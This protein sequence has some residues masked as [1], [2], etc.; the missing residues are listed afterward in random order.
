MIKKAIAVYLD[1]SDKMETE[2]SWLYKTWLLWGLETE[3]DL[4]VYYN[5]E[6]KHRVDKFV[7]IKPI[8]M[9]YVRISEKYKFLNSHYFCHDVTAAEH[10]K[11]YDYLMKTDCDV[12][13][14][15][16]LKG[17]TPSKFMIG[18]GGYYQIED[19]K[20][21]EYI[22]NLSKEFGL[23]HKGYPFIGAS[24]FGKTPLVVSVTANQA[25]L[26]EKLLLHTQNDKKF[27]EVGFQSGIV[28]MIAGELIVNHL[29]TH[30]HFIPYC[31]DSKCWDTTKIGS[32]VLHIHAWHTTQKWSKHEYLN[33]DY[34]NWKVDVK[35]AFKNAANYC[36]FI[37]QLPYHQ[38]HELREKYKKGEF[39]PDYDLN[40]ETKPNDEKFSV[41]L[42][43][44]W[45]SDKTLKLIDDL[46]ECPLVDEI[47]IV[48]NSPKD[49]PKINLKK[50]KFIKQETNIYVNPSWNLG[51]KLAKNNL[52]AI[53]NDDI[54]F[55]VNETFNYVFNNKN[56]LGSIG[57]HP[58][59]YTN[60]NEIGIEIGYHTNGGGWGCLIFCKKDN[61][62]QIPENLKIGYG[63]DWIAITN[64]PT[65]SLKHKT[66][67]ITD[68]STTS[69]R[70]EF[71]SVVSSDIRTWKR[72]FN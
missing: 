23:S 12:F 4:V 70:S 61:W 45:K 1:N 7:G 52:L 26:T 36:Q 71:N 20:K 41:I 62:I 63:D 46:N 56:Q 67:I 19:D 5:P 37:A 38:L 28:S 53:C 49:A 24:F 25:T 31:L 17:F 50:V 9:P 47:I 33:G 3:Y 72:I 6:A 54:N 8:P 15:E 40:S 65:F 10:L 55:N 42:P 68:M 58:Q 44:M 34:S 51:V 66:K 48:D 14:T 27:K 22:K 35:D 39:K 21:I 30:Q 29:L 69:S 64:K 60:D 11:K 16:N 32:N 13:L 2:F 59:S 43:T 57:V 18:E